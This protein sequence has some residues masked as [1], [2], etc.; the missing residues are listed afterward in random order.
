MGKQTGFDFARHW[1]RTKLCSVCFSAKRTR[2]A[3]ERDAVCATEREGVV[4]FNAITLGA[5]FHALKILVFGG[6][7]RATKRTSNLSSPV[8]ERICSGPVLSRE[9]AALGKGLAILL[10]KGVW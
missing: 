6:I 3:N 7:V 4:G 2:A 10:G 5:T 1:T 9:V 8:F